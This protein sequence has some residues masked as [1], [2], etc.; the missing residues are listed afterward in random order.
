VS[1]CQSQEPHT[2][3][4][5]VRLPLHLIQA[6]SFLRLAENSDYTE[7]NSWTEAGVAKLL[8][9]IDHFCEMVF[10]FASKFQFLDNTQNILLKWYNKFKPNENSIRDDPKDRDMIEKVM[11]YIRDVSSPLSFLFL[12]SNCPCELN[13]SFCLCRTLSTVPKYCLC[14]CG[15]EKRTLVTTSLSLC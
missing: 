8:F 4:C 10:S 5:I 1:F 7:R 15:M 13:V 6:H 12:Q 9:T 2:S 11:P 14:A 3:S